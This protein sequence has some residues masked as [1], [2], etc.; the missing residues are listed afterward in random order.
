[1]KRLA[2]WF[3]LFFERLRSKTPRFMK[4]WGAFLIFLGVVVGWM[5]V[6]HASGQLPEPIEKHFIWIRFVY[7]AIVTLTPYLATKNPELSQKTPGKVIE[8]KRVEK[9]IE[10][11]KRN[12]EILNNI[13]NRPK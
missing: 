7:S 3:T 4:D 1:M 6:Q 5:E 2:A 9:E 13:R 10:E 8:E 12:Q 11:E